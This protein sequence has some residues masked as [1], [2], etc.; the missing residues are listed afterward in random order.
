MLNKKISFD[1]LIFFGAMACVFLAALDFKGRYY[2]CIFIAFA[3]F[4]LFPRQKLRVNWSSLFLLGL[5]MAIMICDPNSRER[6]TNLIRPFTF[7]LT[8]TMGMSLLKEGWSLREKEAM[9]MKVILIL[10]GGAC[11]H[12]VLNMVTNL[13]AQDRNTID[14]WTKSV[15]SAT[16]QA[17]LA[18]MMVGV[19]AATLYSDRKRGWKWLAGAVLLVVI[20]YNLILA[21][22]TLLVLMA[23]VLLLAGLRWGI[24]KKRLTWKHLFLAALAIAGVVVL[25][26]QDA[27]GIRTLV[28]SSNFYQRFNGKETDW[29]LNSG[30]LE[31]KRMY[32]DYL[33]DYPMGG[34]NILNM[35]GEYAHDLYLDTYD[36][37]G[38]FSLIAVAA[39]I[40]A[41]LCR[42]FKIMKEPAVSFDLKQLLLC[43]Y[44]VINIQFWLE[45]ILLGV[46]WLLAAYCMM[47]GMVAYLL[48]SARAERRTVRHPRRVKL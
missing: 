48:L 26:Q 18:C 4:L 14:F 12:Y 42:F 22:R 27:F 37:A 23:G 38:V 6:I 47:D 19:V 40:C 36:Q 13:D 11:A 10:A 34:S 39:Y 2:Y 30:R 46:P 15:M 31:R 3:L 16:R 8:Y 44:A 25:Y 20:G 21:G 5:A 1:K 7:F 45:P 32:L 41:S 29:L 28:E 9:V 24:T 17:C 33:W 35:T 43:L